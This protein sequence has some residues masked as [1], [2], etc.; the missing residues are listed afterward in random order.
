MEGDGM[1]KIPRITILVLI[2]VFVFGAAYAQFAKPENAI[3]Y[4][5]AVMTLMA[6]HFSRMGAVIQGKAEYDKDEF[7]AN[8]DVV[9][10]LATLPWDAFMEPGTDK[11]DTKLSSAAFDKPAQ[12]NKVAESLEADTAML[13]SIAKSGDLDAIKAQF[14]KVAQ[15]CGACHKQN[16]SDLCLVYYDVKDCDDH[17]RQ[18]QR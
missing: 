8:A 13:A 11:G 14:G 17:R 9:K 2:A 15:N 7:S 12:F 18:K 10:M 6:Q 3:R 4:R 16:R 5:K 1:K